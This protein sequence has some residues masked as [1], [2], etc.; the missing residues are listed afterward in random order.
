MAKEKGEKGRDSKPKVDRRE[1]GR[2]RVIVRVLGTDLDGEKGVAQA[3]LKI[4]GVSHSFANAICKAAKIDPEKKLG[5]FTESEIHELEEAIKDPLK[6]GVPAWVVN[7]RRDIESGGD[8]HMSSSDVV[9]TKKFDVQRMIDKRTYK[10][11]RHML[12]LPV[13]GQR[14]R[15]SFRK[16]KTVGVVRKSARIAAGGGGKREKKK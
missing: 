12:G 4:K 11:T 9:V 2:A 10:G 6:H 8:M 1:A 16:G 3:I 14:T 13:R 5:T 7:R 15:S